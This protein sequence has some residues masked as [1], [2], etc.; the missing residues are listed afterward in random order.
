MC[1]I[2]WKYQTSS[3]FC[4]I[5]IG[6]KL[7]FCWKNIGR[8]VIKKMC[9]I[10]WKYWTSSNLH[11]FIGFRLYFLLKKT[12]VYGTSSNLKECLGLFE[13]TGR[14]VIFA[15]FYIGFKLYFLL[16]KYWT[17][18]YLKGCVELFENTERPV[19]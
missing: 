14:P 1:R 16:E 18:S 15:Q 19:I 6:S 7:Y 13:N 10:V 4:T 2:V 5:Y 12:Y 3:I 9:R 11:N 17:S 8:P